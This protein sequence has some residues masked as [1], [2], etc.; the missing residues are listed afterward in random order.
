MFRNTL[1][2][3]NDKEKTRD[4]FN[5]ILMED[6]FREKSLVYLVL[7]LVPGGELFEA[8]ENTPDFCF[9][10][11]KSCNFTYQI[12]N[13]VEF[14]HSIQI[15]HL[16]LKPENILCDANLTRIKIAD[17][18]ISLDLS[19]Y[20]KGEAV[21]N[22][23]GTAEYISPEA[24]NFDPISLKTDMWSVGVILHILVTGISP[25]Y[26]IE[27]DSEMQT[28]FNVCQGKL[29]F[30]YEEFD[31]VSEE[32]KDL[33]IKLIE[34]DQRKRL[35]AKESK[36]HAFIALHLKRPPDMPYLPRTLSKNMSMNIAKINAATKRWKK[37]KNSIKASGLLQQVRKNSGGLSIFN[38]GTKLK[39]SD[40][41]FSCSSTESNVT[42]IERNASLDSMPS[43]PSRNQTLTSRISGVSIPEDEE[44]LLNEISE[45]RVVEIV[46]RLKLDSDIQEEP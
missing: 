1:K 21:K 46:Q 14:L 27:N 24:L 37:L 40:S 6:Y 31:V 32:A 36:Q 3:Q 7:E 18:G 44:T 11:E 33:I 34:K 41:L 12:L 16:D 42:V 13:A 23:A 26:D 35:S 19:T 15:V 9:T 22:M 4:S 8:L 38:L 10:E 30:S 45:D 28:K 39:Q 43:M 20:K 5:I 17:F 29:D 25:F 2:L